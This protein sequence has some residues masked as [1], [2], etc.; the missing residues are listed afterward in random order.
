MNEI[1]EFGR[2]AGPV[3]NK[4]KTSLKWQKQKWNFD[5]FGLQWEEGCIKYLGCYIGTDLELVAKLNWET[6]LEKIQRVV[7]NWR[8]RNLTLIGRVIII[9]T[10]LISQI[11][12]LIMFCPVS[13]SVMKQLDKIIYEYLWGSK[14][15][16]VKKR[17]HC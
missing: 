14:V 12:H 8:K 3:I 9:K 16:K 7:D 17:N 10:L 4:T 15:N 11:V 13:Q 1:D 6:K 5:G 2:V